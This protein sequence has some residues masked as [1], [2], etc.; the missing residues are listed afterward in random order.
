MAFRRVPI[1]VVLAVF[2]GALPNTEGSGRAVPMKKFTVDLDKPPQERWIDLL[3]HYTT[4]VPLIVDY[5][6][7]Q[8][9][10]HRRFSSLIDTLTVNSLVPV[11]FQDPLSECQRVWERD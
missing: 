7:Q 3:S 6:D 2:C 11:S 10:T 4:S 8:V 5:F 9:S 1:V